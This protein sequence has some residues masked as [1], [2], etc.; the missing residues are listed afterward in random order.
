[1]DYEKLTK[2]QIAEHLREEQQK[3]V[4]LQERLFWEKQKGVSKKSSDEIIVL[5]KEKEELT[6]QIN[7]LANNLLEAKK[8][9]QEQNDI[10][11]GVEEYLNYV[12]SFLL[13]SKSSLELFINLKD[14][15][16]KEI[17]GG[18]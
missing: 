6:L 2:K 3:V 17:I 10:I 11:K 7:Q 15:T 14:K 18:K 16:L 1:M 4:D 12:E 5:Q 9:I 13:Q 8:T